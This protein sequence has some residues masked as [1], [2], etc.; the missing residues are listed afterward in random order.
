MSKFF[1][2]NPTTNQRTLRL[3]DQF[4]VADLQTDYPV[5]FPG[6][7]LTLSSSAPIADATDA[8]A[9]Y[10]LPYIHNLIPI[11]DGSYWQYYEVPDAGITMPSLTGFAGAIYDMFA[12]I[13]SG[14]MQMD[15]LAWST[16]TARTSALTRKNGILVLN[17]NN[18]MTYLGSVM[19]TGSA[20][21][22]KY[23]DNETRRFLWNRYNQVNKRLWKFESTA[24]WT[25]SSAT[26]RMLNNSSANRVEIL[27]GIGDGILDL[28]Q[29]VRLVPSTGA[30]AVTGIGIDSTSS[31]TDAL[32]SSAANT[33]HSRRLSRSVGQGYH[34]AQALEACFDSNSVTFY[35][36]GQSGLEGTWLC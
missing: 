10:Y 14:T 19:T 2:F 29:F 35:G 23:H 26:A 27:D 25:Y 1:A 9:C 20:G 17:S 7:R 8:T 5:C 32:I 4:S 11:W 31:I 12:E 3:V 21:S 28:G 24:S 13:Q 22:A 6:G 18:S 36:S 34:F 16:N 30:G 33:T 15:Y